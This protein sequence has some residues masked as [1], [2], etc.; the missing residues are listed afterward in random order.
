MPEW[1]LMQAPQLP[2]F[3]A[4][5]DGKRECRPGMRGGHQMCL[6][7]SSETIFLFGGWDGNQDLSDMWAYHIPTQKW[8]MV[9]ADTSLEVCL[10]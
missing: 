9:S 1:I 6:D 10:F 7:P 5:N 2:E 4:G 3:P 8:R